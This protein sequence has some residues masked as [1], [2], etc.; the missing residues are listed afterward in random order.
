MV[1][2]LVCFDHTT[3]RSELYITIILFSGTF[4]P[5]LCDIP[6]E[7]LPIHY[8]GSCPRQGP[9]QKRPAAP[10]DLGHHAGL[11]AV[12]CR[13]RGYLAFDNSLLIFD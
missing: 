10:G 12:L 7:A 4:Y 3:L 6:E 11:P 5:G 1:G 2:F 13:V 9:A 8:G